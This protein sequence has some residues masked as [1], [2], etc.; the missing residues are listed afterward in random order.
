[1]NPW[2]KQLVLIVDDTPHNIRLL[3]SLLE[4]F[5]EIAIATDGQQ[6]LEMVQDTPPD[7]ILLDVM[8]PVLDGW[9]TCRRLQQDPSTQDIPIIFLTAKH[10]TE[11]IVRGFSLGAVDYLAK[12]VIRE[13]PLARVGVHLKLRQSIL[14]LRHIASTDSLTGI[15]NRRALFQRLEEAYK[16][17]L[18]HNYPLSILMLDI[19]FF[20]RINDTWGHQA[21]DSVLT[22]TAETIRESIRDTDLLG[23]FGG[24]EFLVVL[25]HTTLDGGL[26]VAEKIRR[27]LESLTWPIQNL[28]VTLSGGLA[29]LSNSGGIDPLIQRADQNLYI[30]KQKGRNRIVC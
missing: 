11:D 2:D 30:A 7:L 16:L 17:S 1:M 19:D 27:N 12:P 28:H 20:K 18:R 25:P 3:G 24:E 22:V 6:A 29:S 8:M 5:Y 13:E 21:G 4:P 23:R 15:L 10:E 9:E 14:E 26:K